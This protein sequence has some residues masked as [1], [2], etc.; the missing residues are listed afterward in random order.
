LK[1]GVAFAG[2]NRYNLAQNDGVL[3]GVDMSWNGQILRDFYV[4]Q[5]AFPQE[6]RRYF[7]GKQRGMAQKDR[8]RWQPRGCLQIPK[9]AGLRVFSAISASLS[10]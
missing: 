9:H 2:N 1:Q 3:G 7:K 5:G 4:F 6:Y 10:T 8:D